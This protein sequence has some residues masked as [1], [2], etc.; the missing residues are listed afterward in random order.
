MA[1]G[2][3]ETGGVYLT[4]PK[5]Q[6]ES[7]ELLRRIHERTGWQTEELIEHLTILWSQNTRSSAFG[8]LFEDKRR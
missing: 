5:E 6:N 7:L 2:S 1:N 3:F 8:Q 4:D